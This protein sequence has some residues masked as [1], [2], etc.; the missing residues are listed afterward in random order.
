MTDRGQQKTSK[1]EPKI[2]NEQENNTEQQHSPTHPRQPFEWTDERTNELIETNDTQRNLPLTTVWVARAPYTIS[3]HTNIG[4]R[5]ITFDCIQ[6][7]IPG[8]GLCLI[9]TVVALSFSNLVA[10]SPSSTDKSIDTNA[11]DVTHTQYEDYP[12]WT[13]DNIRYIWSLFGLN[14]YRYH[15]GAN[16]WRAY[17]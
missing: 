8:V 13:T 14:R 9:P 7:C 16:A 15:T 1:K 12:I 4:K 2:W 17:R 3:R 10:G 11:W 5:G 6:S